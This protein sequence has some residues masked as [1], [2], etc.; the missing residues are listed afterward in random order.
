RT[1]RDLQRALRLRLDAEDVGG[2]AD[3]SVQ[4][5]HAV[6]FEAVMDAEAVA[7]GRGEHSGPCRRADEREAGQVETERAGARPAPD[8]DVQLEILHRWIENLMDGAVEAG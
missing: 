5:V 1:L 3:D 7:Q 6:E 2:A 4:F 8:D